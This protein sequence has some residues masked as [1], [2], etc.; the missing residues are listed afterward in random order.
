MSLSVDNVYGKAFKADGAKKTEPMPAK[1]LQAILDAFTGE[2]DQEIKQ[3]KAELKKLAKNDPNV[4]YLKERLD[5]LEER[6]LT[7]LSRISGA[8]GRKLLLEAEARDFYDADAGHAL[9]ACANATLWTIGYG[10][11]THRPMDA[12]L[13]DLPKDKKVTFNVICSPSSHAGGTDTEMEKNF[14]EFARTNEYVAEIYHEAA[15]GSRTLL[16]SKTFKVK[17]PPEYASM[18][19]DMTV[20]LSKLKGGKLIVEGSAIGSAGV[21]GYVEARRTVIHLG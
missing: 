3:V 8:A 21:E 16:D 5:K 9:A 12:F 11:G 2:I 4:S 17:N 1:K 20:D 7:D 6:K 14:E 19:P 15:D 10:Y 13:T 18:S